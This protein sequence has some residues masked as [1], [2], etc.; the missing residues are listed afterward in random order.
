M[1]FEI[2]ARDKVEAAIE[3]K[4]YETTKAAYPSS[5]FLDDLVIP[6]DFGV[7]EKKAFFVS[8]APLQPANAIF[9]YLFF[10][11]DSRAMGSFNPR[12]LVYKALGF[13]TPNYEAYAL[14]QSDAVYQIHR[15]YEPMGTSPSPYQAAPQIGIQP[16]NFPLLKPTELSQFAYAGTNASP[17]YDMPK[18]VI[19]TLNGNF[20]QTTS[21][22]VGVY[23][24]TE[25]RLGE[26]KVQTRKTLENVIEK[27]DVPMHL[28]QSQIS[29]MP[30]S[31][32]MQLPPK[33]RRGVDFIISSYFAGKSSLPYET[34]P[35][36]QILAS[37]VS[38]R[39]IL[40]NLNPLKAN[41]YSKTQQH[42]Y[43]KP[44]TPE[45]VMA[46]SKAQQYILNEESQNGKHEN[47][48]SF[49][50]NRVH[51]T[52]Q[53]SNKGKNQ[54]SNVI[55]LSNYRNPR[56]KNN[57]DWQP[58]NI[59]SNYKTIL[60]NSNRKLRE[61][62]KKNNDY[63]LE[64]ARNT[65]NQFYTN[66]K[67]LYSKL[68]GKIGP[69][70][71]VGQ[72]VTISESLTSRINL[73]S[74]PDSK[75]TKANNGSLDYLQ[76]IVKYLEY[77]TGAK[78]PYVVMDGLTGEVLA[79]KDADQ[80]VSAG[81]LP[82]IFI[83]KI[84]LELSQQGKI[85]LDGE[86]KLRNSQRPKNYTNIERP[87]T[88]KEGMK[89]MNSNEYGNS[90][91][92]T[93]ALMEIIGIK[94][95]NK[96]LEQQGYHKTVI[97]DYFRPRGL[98]RENKT[99]ANDTSMAL[100]EMITG[101]GLDDRHHKIGL[102][103]LNAKGMIYPI[104]DPNNPDGIDTTNIFGKHGQSGH[105]ISMASGIKGVQSGKEFNRIIV[106]IE[107]GI[108]KRIVKGDFKSPAPGGLET[109]QDYI[110]AY[111]QFCKTAQMIGYKS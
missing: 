50:N 81:S 74:Q 5:F 33:Y 7:L 17:N 13:P 72:A 43:Q 25:A 45:V 84:L 93:T 32:S 21:S 80:S 48:D 76:N 60:R 57:S 104:C 12:Y 6:K 27:T 19:E 37:G 42:G 64:L 56:R 77:K 18:H 73:N 28:T 63:L 14:Q 36:T 91:W 78:V 40:I 23:N 82:K 92:V 100:F 38:I 86:L 20:W 69:K 8:C 75:E 105:D 11:T 83:A 49:Q 109:M 44:D 87:I 16:Y 90:N 51:K 70:I 29:Q 94:R 65:F 24:S 35:K 106:L 59:K 67:S 103:V 111:R 79:D 10:G 41:N 15:D 62:V 30:Q 22:F 98:Y 66:A 61:I 58:K 88:I 68:K 4:E 99:S 31:V 1:A 53:T 47:E 110:N 52:A 85:N 107:S 3:Q 108:N 71:N 34:T 96:M 39:A 102:E 89:E 101:K 46:S 55:Y 2:C 26:E 54:N 95:I 97:A 9:D